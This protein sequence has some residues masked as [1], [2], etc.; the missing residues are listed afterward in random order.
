MKKVSDHI[1]AACLY[2]YAN[3]GARLEILK[4]IFQPIFFIFCSDDHSYLTNAKRKEK[5][6]LN[7][8][9]KDQKRCTKYLNID[10]CWRMDIFRGLLYLSNTK[11]ATLPI[12]VSKILVQFDARS[13]GVVYDSSWYWKFSKILLYCEHFLR[14]K[15]TKFECFKF[16]TTWSI[17]LSVS[18]YGVWSRSAL[19]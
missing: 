11:S 12:K 4:A 3:E 15:C 1:Q 16:N 18:E 10:Q 17:Y 6:S 13:S 7:R 2:F 8:V 14:P 5:K 19:E 9:K